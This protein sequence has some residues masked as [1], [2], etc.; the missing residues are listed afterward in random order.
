MKRH[1]TFVKVR[2][3]ETDQMGVVHHGN[4]AEYLEIAR[5]DWL[6][7]LG[8]S[9]KSLEKEGVMLPVYELNTKFIKPAYFDDVLRIETQLKELPR[10]KIEFSYQVFNQQDELITTAYTILV[11]MDSKTKKPIRCPEYILDKIK[12]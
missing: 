12:S 1:H 9:Y 8:V 10:V 2:Y 6:D 11:F 3:A 7:Q 5:L 4:Y